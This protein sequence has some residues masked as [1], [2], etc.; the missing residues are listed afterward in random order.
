[1]LG[2][3]DI[4]VTT[5]KAKKLQIH[6]SSKVKPDLPVRRNA[7]R[8]YWMEAPLDNDCANVLLHQ[9]GGS[10]TLTHQL[11]DGTFLILLQEQLRLNLDRDCEPMGKEGARGALF[12]VRLT[13][14][15]YTVVAKGTVRAFVEDLHYGRQ[16]YARLRAEQ[17]E[18]VPVCLG[19]IDLFRPY[20][21][22]VGVRIIQMMILS[23]AGESFDESTSGQAVDSHGRTQGLIRSLEA[24]HRQGV[25]HGDVRMPNVL[26]NE[27]TGR[28][29]L[30]DFE[31]S[32]IVAP[33]RQPL[34][35]TGLNSKGKSSSAVNLLHSKT[36][37]GA[38][39]KRK[40]GFEERFEAERLE[41]ARVLV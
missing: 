40:F 33:M 12:K 23:W 16:T 4:P 31:R 38:T 39:A 10:D 37:S 2:E 24:I 1:M 32:T 35:L 34:S 29:M 26:W 27:E 30:V 28:A 11:D 14:H 5:A 41:A 15:G 19:N 21:Y 20:I 18:F 8:V 7:S 22:D 6:T 13:S 25:L 3:L 17:G 9:K 36:T